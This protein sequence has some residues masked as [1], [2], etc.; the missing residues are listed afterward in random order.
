MLE[1]EEMAIV[2]TNIKEVVEEAVL[3]KLFLL[4]AEVQKKKKHILSTG[5]FKP[6]AS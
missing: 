1:V 6:V 4:H 2:F 3:Q 5:L